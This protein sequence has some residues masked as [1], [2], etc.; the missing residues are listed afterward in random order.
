MSLLWATKGAPGLKAKCLRKSW[1]INGWVIFFSNFDDT[2]AA[3]ANLDL[4]ICVD[5][6]VAHLAA[7]MGKPVWMLAALRNSEWRW[8]DHGNGNAWYPNLRVFFQ[9]KPD[10]WLGLIKNSVRPALANHV[11]SV[12][13]GKLPWAKML[14]E[15][16]SSRKSAKDL[17]WD[18]LAIDVARNGEA[19][20]FLDWCW[21]WL[22]EEGHY[23]QILA[24][25][26]LCARE[27]LSVSS[28]LL[29]QLRVYALKLSGARD[30]AIA[31]WARM[32]R[33]PQIKELSLS[34]R[35]YIEWGQACF[36]NKSSQDAV[37][38]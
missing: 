24:L 8:T 25:C 31:E 14:L 34:R 5:T 22:K 17:D 10:D 4:V 20:V 37:E 3:I 2:A 23:E 11:L 15:I 26:S 32:A 13:H 36:E 19:S 18:A 28:A 30:E 16:D 7:A 6:S 9:E 35:A 12:G 38:I 29:D 27:S 1:L 33:S 21:R